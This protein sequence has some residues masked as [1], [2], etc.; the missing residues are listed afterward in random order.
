MIAEERNRESKYLIYGHKRSEDEPVKSWHGEYGSKVSS[1][2]GGI[3]M[4]CS[5]SHVKTMDLLAH[6]GEVKF[7]HFADS[8]A[9]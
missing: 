8:N 7:T 5:L 1:N 3:G 9:F 6:P 2:F 4:L